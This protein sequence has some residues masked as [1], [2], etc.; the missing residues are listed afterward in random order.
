MENFKSIYES[1]IDSL[2]I[3]KEDG[4]N[5]A[6]LHMGEVIIDLDKSMKVVAIEI[7]NPDYIFKVPKRLFSEIEKASL[8]IQQ[9]NNVLW[10]LIVLKFKSKEC[11]LKIP[12]SVPLNTP[13]PV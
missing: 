6:S 10:I 12:L 11:P 13:I 1:E 2:T 9:R 5:Y 8:A 4:Q 3:Y 7:L